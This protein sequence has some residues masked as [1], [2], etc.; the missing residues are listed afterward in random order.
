VKRHGHNGQPDGHG[1]MMHRRTGA[2]GA[3]STPARVWIT[4]R[5]PDM[6]G[7]FVARPRISKLFKSVRKME[8]SS[9]RARFP[10]TTVLTSLFARLLKEPH[11]SKP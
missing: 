3:G 6:M 2:I 8:S 7:L 1:H 9:F 4:R 5:C 10:A 11:L